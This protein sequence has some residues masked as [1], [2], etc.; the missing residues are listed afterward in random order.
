MPG[1][2]VEHTVLVFALATRLKVPAGQVTHEVLPGRRLYVPAMHSRHTAK[3]LPPKVI[4][5][6]PAEQAIHEAMELAPVTRLNVPAAQATHALAPGT[7]LYVP[8][9][10]ALHVV[11]WSPAENVPRPHC[12]HTS[13]DWNDALMLTIKPAGQ[14]MQTAVPLDR[15][16]LGTLPGQAG[17]ARKIMGT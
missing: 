1:R 5:K 11:D 10:Q 14:L 2:Q 8:A 16:R 4:P 7:G 15:H 3:E 9:E 12:T 17:H 13:G 6:L